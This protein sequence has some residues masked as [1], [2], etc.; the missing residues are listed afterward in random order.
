MEHMETP[1]RVWASFPVDDDAD[2]AFTAVAIRS[3]AVVT[4]YEL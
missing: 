3:G 2:E 1:W 4:D